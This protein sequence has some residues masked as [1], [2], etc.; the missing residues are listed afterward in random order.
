MPDKLLENTSNPIVYFYWF[1]YLFYLFQILQ[2]NPP[3]HEC[4][5][6]KVQRARQKSYSIPDFFKT[7]RNTRELW[8]AIKFLSSARYDRF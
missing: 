6:R 3:Y 4:Y 5:Q 1:I 7:E 2:D 8:R